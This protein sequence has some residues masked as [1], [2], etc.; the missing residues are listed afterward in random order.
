MTTPRRERL[1][2][3]KL[4]NIQVGTTSSITTIDLLGDLDPAKTNVTVVRQLI[5]LTIYPDG[6]GD[7]VDGGQMLDLGIG[8]VS[9]EAHSANVVPDPASSLD[10]PRDGWLW[11]RRCVVLNQQSGVGEWVYARHIDDDSRSQRKVDRGVLFL[12]GD[13]AVSSGVGFTL[14]ICG[15]IRTLVLL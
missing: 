6:M 1:W 11:L 7:T 2:V 14:R 3:D 10:Y 4:I 12:S 5:D 8:V 15:R 9:A 13:N